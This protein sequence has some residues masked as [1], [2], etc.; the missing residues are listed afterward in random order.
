MTLFIR[1]AYFG[2]RTPFLLNRYIPFSKEHIL[3]GKEWGKQGILIP[4]VI[5]PDL[6][7]DNYSGIDKLWDKLMRHLGPRPQNTLR[8]RVQT[9]NLTWYS[10][11]AGAETDG[12][13]GILI[14]VVPE[15]VHYNVINNKI[16]VLQHSICT[17]G[18]CN[19]DN[20]YHTYNQTLQKLFVNHFYLGWK[21]LKINKL[22]VLQKH[23]KTSW[24]KYTDNKPY[25]NRCFL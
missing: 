3:N 2:I 13:F 8:I 11:K 18:I 5:Q 16:S 4:E 21:Y 6:K 9:L 25:L 24:W 7:W 10:W 23:L 1:G 19:G 20:R 14:A 15:E 22:C 17:V 12:Q